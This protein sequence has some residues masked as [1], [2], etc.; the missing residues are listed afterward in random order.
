M[1]WLLIGGGYLGLGILIISL[2]PYRNHYLTS[3]T[4]LS[5][6]PTWKIYLYYFLTY[7]AAVL[8]WPFLLKIFYTKPSTLLDA[9]EDFSVKYFQLACGLPD[10]II[11]RISAEVIDS[12]R[13][14]AELK[15]ERIS[16]GSLLKISSKFMI[17]Y[18]N[19]GAD[20]YQSHLEYELEK[21]KNDGLREDYL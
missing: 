8:L 12:F 3:D 1:N 9:T 17:V 21:Y 2:C 5:N 18:E 11:K 14:V 19:F 6:V 13:K 20:Y 7:T 4:N 16:G 10:E 15:G